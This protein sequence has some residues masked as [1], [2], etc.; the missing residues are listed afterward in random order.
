MTKEEIKATIERIIK[1]RKQLN[2]KEI[3][4]CKQ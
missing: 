3:K 2:G 4:S 1:A